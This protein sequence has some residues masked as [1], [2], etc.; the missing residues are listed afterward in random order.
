M[1]NNEIIISKIKQIITQKGERPKVLSEQISFLLKQIPELVKYI[2]ENDPTLKDDIFYDLGRYINYHRF[3]KGE[4]IQ[5]IC[6]GDKL[7]FMI[8]TGKIVKI[9]IKYKKVTTTLKEYI[10]YLTKLQ[11]LE[12]YFLLSDCIDKNQDIF[13][14][15]LERNM[16]KIFSRLQGFDFKREFKKIKLEI[17]NS[18]WRNNPSDIEDYINLI[19]PSFI[20][21]KKSFLSKDMKFPVILPHYIKDEILGANTFLGN[22]LKCKGIKE[23][24]SYICINNA[25]ILYIDKSTVAPGCK[26][27]NIIDN[28]LNYSVINDIIKKNIIF[29]NTNIDHLIKYYS[30]YFRL[31]KISKGQMLISQGRP[32]EGIYFINKGIFQLKT[33]KSFYELQELIFNL[34][35]S[36]DSFSNYISYIKKREEDDLN[37]GGKNIQKKLFIYKHPLFLI[38]CNQ[39]KEIYFSSFHAPQIMGLN[40]LYGS[41]TGVYHFSISC[42]SDEAEVYFLPNELVNNL[43]SNNSIYNSIASLI[44]ER[45]KFLLFTI[46]KYKTKFEEEFEK[47]ILSSK[48]S[49]I[50]NFNSKSLSPIIKKLSSSRNL[51]NGIQ[52]NEKSYNEIS[53]NNNNVKKN[54]D[55]NFNNINSNLLSLDSLNKLEKNKI[56][57]NIKEQEKNSNVF[58]RMNLNN[59]FLSSLNHKSKNILSDNNKSLEKTEIYHLHNDKNIIEKLNKRIIKSPSALDIKKNIDKILNKND[60]II[61]N[62]RN[63]NSAEQNDNNQKIDNKR[64]MKSKLLPLKQISQNKDYFPQ[65]KYKDNPNIKLCSNNTIIKENNFLNKLNLLYFNKNK[66]NYQNE[67]INNEREKK[68]FNK[69]NIRRKFNFKTDY[70]NIS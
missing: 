47:Y 45:V 38:K 18:K 30:K 4:I 21:G 54:F 31:I 17:R 2:N 28:R 6:E 42:I 51:I 24:S 12:E 69:L 64:K 46:K 50:K 66:G 22:L 19:N 56:T 59:K 16:I 43:L 37:S 62:S 68:A 5:R 44:E 10:L 48:V 35:D 49:Q 67:E 26:L 27:M 58:N 8:V 33:E 52:F 53:E 11:L 7:F 3:I 41:K 55:E 9:G 29:K 15:K 1:S 14:F 39:K 34:R 25:D 40:E 65:I 13:P 63:Y 70:G 36:L 20:T 60:S 57:L 32:H 23:F 61:N